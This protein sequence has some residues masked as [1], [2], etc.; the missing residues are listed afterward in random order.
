MNDVCPLGVAG[1][2]TTVGAKGTVGVVPGSIKYCGAYITVWEVCM[3]GGTE[4][5]IKQVQVFCERKPISVGTEKA[6]L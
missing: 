2:V 6:S 3:Y 4:K 5:W 1:K